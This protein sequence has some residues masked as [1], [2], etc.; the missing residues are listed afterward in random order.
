MS[1]LT[2]SFFFCLL[3]ASYAPHG[4]TQAPV[5]YVVEI[6][7]DWYLNGN[8]ASPLKRWQ[9]LPPGGTLSI[10]PP[11]PDARIVVSDL[12]GK[13]IDSRNC[14]AVDCSRPFKLPGSSPQRS[15]LRVAFD[16]TVGL[17]FGSPDR[18]SI[19]RNRTFGSALS[20][21]VVRLEGGQ[22]DLSP[23]LRQS[24]RYYLRW[25]SRPRSGETGKWSTPIGL[26]TE[27]GQ[28][29]LVAVPDLKPGLY[30]INLQR[31]VGDS[32]ETFASAWVLVSTS[33]G[34]ENAAASFRQAVELTEQWGD[35]VEPNTSRQFLRAHLDYLAEQAGK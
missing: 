21:G 16:A 15:L 27:R 8:T 19:H 17:L 7:G 33:P 32:Y 34:H 9:K 11:T 24:G 18:Y 35:K 14:E 4:A 20:D 29:A 2:V 13:I 6:H 26:R 23:V 5:G 22:I 10:K 12:S 1:I 31:R 30:E 25:R 28:P 3:V